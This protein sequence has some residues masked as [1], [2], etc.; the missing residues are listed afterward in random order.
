MIHVL[1]PLHGLPLEGTSSS[2]RLKVLEV[3][4]QAEARLFVKVP[5]LKLGLL[6]FPRQQDRR[7]LL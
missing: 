2:I 3:F 5:E 7:W 4:S 6:Y 1:W